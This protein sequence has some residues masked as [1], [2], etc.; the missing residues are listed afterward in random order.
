MLDAPTILTLDDEEQITSLIEGALALDGSKVL[1]A[2][3]VQ[4]FSEIKSR[5]DIDIYILDLCVPNMN[6]LRVVKEIREFEDAGIIMLSGHSSEVDVVLGLELGADDYIPK[7]FRLRELRARVAAVHRRRK[8]RALVPAAA[9]ASGQ[10]ATQ[11]PEER[12]KAGAWSINTAGRRVMHES[13]KA[14]V[15]TTSE[16]DVLL[17]LV[18]N[19]NR[20]VT[21]NQIMDALRGESWAAYDRLID[22]FISRLRAKMAAI[23]QGFDSIQTI[24]G[25]GYC[26]SVD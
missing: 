11:A 12:L 4:E 19:R 3:S 25:I 7:P 17:Y 15:L 8:E 21:R 14:L 13:G 16:Y 24:R 10:D 6:I 9:P 18:R 2:N 26:F 5:E 23:D 22:G 1:V 20:V